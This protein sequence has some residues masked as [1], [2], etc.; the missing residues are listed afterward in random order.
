MNGDGGTQ[1]CAASQRTNSAPGFKTI[2]FLRYALW[3][4][5]GGNVCPPAS[6]A[7]IGFTALLHY[8]VR[9][10]RSFAECWAFSHSKEL[11]QAAKSL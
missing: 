5:W 3:L 7:G 8:M 10:D 11:A 4:L 2:D 6:Q 1:T 9:G